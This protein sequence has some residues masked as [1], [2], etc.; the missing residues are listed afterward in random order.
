LQAT[1]DGRSTEI[2]ADRVP[3]EDALSETHDG[4][5]LR[6]R[7]RVERQVFSGG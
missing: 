3:A 4:H 5:D 1:E 7:G 2:A 6:R